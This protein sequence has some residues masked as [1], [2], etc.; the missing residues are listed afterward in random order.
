M[1]IFILLIIAL[2]VSWLWLLH[3]RKRLRDTGSCDARLDLENQ[4]K[5]KWRKVIG[6]P[7]LYDQEL[8]LVSNMNN[9]FKR[10]SLPDFDSYEDPHV[11]EKQLEE[12]VVWARQ[13]DRNKGRKKLSDLITKDLSIKAP[14]IDI[15][16]KG[17]FITTGIFFYYEEY[18]ANGYY[19]EE[20]R[21]YSSV[22]N[23]EFIVALLSSPN[24]INWA[25]MHSNEEVWENDCPENEEWFLSDNNAEY[26]PET[27]EAWEFFE[28]DGIAGSSFDPIHFDIDGDV[29]F[30]NEKYTINSAKFK[31]YKKEKDFLIILLMATYN[32][33]LLSRVIAKLEA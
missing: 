33:D 12:F 23:N 7:G 21:C 6:I 2:G 25:E 28:D 1:K 11:S 26:V 16:L 18:K 27:G 31:I 17:V 32:S 13:T 19:I 3:P 15:A 8:E 4:R 29:G 9:T 10:P 20:R 5:E 24:L 14:D 22:I 30:Y